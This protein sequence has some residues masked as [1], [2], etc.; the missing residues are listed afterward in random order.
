MTVGNDDENERGE[1]MTVDAENHDT[2][3]RKRRALWFVLPVVL[4][5][6]AGAAFVV[7]QIRDVTNA[8]Y[9]TVTYT[10]PDA[11]RLVATP[12]EFVYRIDPSQSSLEYRVDE[13]IVGAKASTAVGKTSGIAGDIAV[14]T[15]NPAKSRIGKI[16]ANIEQFQSDN[17]LRDARIR[18]DFLVSH[19]F[20]LA[21]FT[22]S[23]LSGLNGPLTKG[24]SQ[25]FTI[26]GKA[27]V[28]DITRPVTWHANG[29]LRDG[30]VE[31][32]AT[33]KIKLSDFDIDHVSVAGLVS[34]S[35]DATLTMR[36]VAVDP[37][38]VSLPTQ[39]N[40]SQAVK[41]SGKSPSFK[42][43]IQPILESHCAACHEPGSVGATHWELTD[44]KDASDVAEGLATVTGAKYMPPWPASDKGVPLDHKNT[45]NSSQITAIAD[46]ARG[47]GKLDVPA[48]TKITAAEVKA[49]LMPR[50]DVELRLPAPYT[51]NPEKPNDYRCFVLDPKV[52]EPTYL[53]GYTFLADVVPQ[54]HHAQVFLISAAQKADAAK[55]SGKDG[56]PGWQCFGT[57][58]LNGKPATAGFSPRK[59]AGFSGQSNLVAGWVPGQLP[60]VYPL[61]SAVMLEPGDALV[62]QIHYH[63]DDKVKPDQSGIALQLDSAATTK[64][65]KVR[66]VNPL[67]PVEIPCAPGVKAKLCDRNEALKENVRL[68]GP[69]GAGT[70]AGLLGLCRH[71]AEELAARFDGQVA[72]SD[73]TSKVPEDGL[74]YGVLGHMHTIG[75]SFRLTLNPGTPQ[76]KVLLDIPSWNFDWQM[77]YKLKEPIKV[78]AGEKVRMECT[79]DRSLA[80]NR[81][82]KYIVF[83]DGTEDEM[84]FGTFAMIPDDQS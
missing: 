80:P 35:N 60:V 75:K 14:N 9:Q 47:G 34:A 76:E 74:I 56:E 29:T 63:F 30:S 11:P 12:G 70:E 79:W 67:A 77:N 6:A 19:E 23:S 50:K 38:D 49:G 31:L 59:S 5:V 33:T 66:V 37:A 25:D 28:R 39:I 10:V 40:A 41:A 44:A 18:S 81:A 26:T 32:T 20:P 45:L 52:T 22:V 78:K 54:L 27:T 3:R 64:R 62:L 43:T 72:S 15:T 82:P 83:A 36:L 17:R 8:P 21:T 73:C 48:N 46:W 84:C 71:T 65:S 61:N 1:T 69:M 57:I 4:V 53:S 24:Q 68:Y 2:P 13:K 51:G 58:S 55:R 7:K 42:T 16:V